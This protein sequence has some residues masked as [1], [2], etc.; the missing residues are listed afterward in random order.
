MIIGPFCNEDIKPFLRLAAQECWVAEQWEFEFLLSTFPQGCFAARSDDGQAAGFVTALRHDSSGWIGN[1]IVEASHRGQKIGEKLFVRALEALRAAGVETIWLTASKS[2][3]SLYEK[4][5]FNSVDTI[6]R[7]VG[8]GRQHHAV[9]DR[10]DGGS[11]ACF[12][13]NEFDFQAW[14]DRR[15]A[16]L[17]A[18]VGRGRLLLEDVA[19]AVIQPC[20]NAQHSGPF[21]ALDSGSAEKV[22]DAA[23]RIIPRGSRIYLDSP[24][25]NR[26]ALRLYNRR[27]MKISGTTELMCAGTRPNYRPDLIYGLATMGSCG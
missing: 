24:A 17:E 6:M 13:V 7:W 25:S 19:F 1:L 2:G 22:F 3:Q 20:G 4:Y 23:L 5:G 26:A 18:T 14:G 9:H 16:L 15:D 11:L 10:A 8:T 12:K 21:T 27:G